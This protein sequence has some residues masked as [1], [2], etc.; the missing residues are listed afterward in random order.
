MSTH[1]A[2][3]HSTVTPIDMAGFTSCSDD[4]ES[5]IGDVATPTKLSAASHAD[6]DDT[7]GSPLK[8]KR[9]N[10]PSDDMVGCQA[11]ARLAH[12]SDLSATA[13]TTS[14]QAERTPPLKKTK[15]K[16]I[17]SDTKHGQLNE[18]KLMQSD[19]L[20]VTVDD[21]ED[22][23]FDEDVNDE[24]YEQIE[25]QLFTPLTPDADYSWDLDQLEACMKQAEQL[26]STSTLI[27]TSSA[28]I[29]S[30]RNES[31]SQTS[32]HSPPPGAN[33]DPGANHEGDESDL[34]D[35]CN[36]HQGKRRPSENDSVKSFL[37]SETKEWASLS[38]WDKDMQSLMNSLAAPSPSF[39]PRETL[40]DR[41]SQAFQETLPSILLGILPS[42][43]PSPRSSGPSNNAAVGED[44]N[45]G[46]KKR[47][48]SV[49]EN[50]EPLDVSHQATASHVAPSEHAQEGPPAK[51]QKLDE[52]P[53]RK[54][55]DSFPVKQKETDR[56]HANFPSFE[57]PTTPSDR[58]GKPV[59]PSGAIW[60]LQDM[61]N[62]S[63]GMA[64]EPISQDSGHL[65]QCGL[66]TRATK[67]ANHDS[68]SVPTPNMEAS[69]DA[70]AKYFTFLD[71][72]DLKRE[73]QHLLIS[74]SHT[75]NDISE[76]LE[77]P[78]ENASG[79]VKT[80][81][82]DLAELYK[83]TLQTSAGS[84]WKV[85]AAI[86]EKTKLTRVDHVLT[87]LFGRYLQ[88]KIFEA[89]HG[90][91]TRDSMLKDM[92][93][94]KDAFFETTSRYLGMVYPFL[95]VSRTTLTCKG[96]SFERFLEHACFQ[97][98]NDP[99]FLA[100][101][102]SKAEDL[103]SDFI[104]IIADHLEATVKKNHTRDDAAAVM[105][106]V[107]DRFDNLGKRIQRTIS[108]AL[109]LKAKLEMSIDEY[110]TTL[111]S[112]K[113]KKDLRVMIEHW[114]SENDGPAMREDDDGAPITFAMT[115]CLE[116]LTQK[117]EKLACPVV[118]ARAQVKYD[119]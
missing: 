22:V 49:L 64:P 54:D 43:L 30:S 10:D 111:Y 45:I 80:P 86:L 62:L 1:K 3:D 67:P 50:D 28:S 40:P 79:F 35:G 4:E 33:H 61:P 98:L 96:V 36:E 119:V 73:Y 82:P 26:S 2:S 69:A 18:R 117:G 39:A 109:E 11:D 52:T 107:I 15:T 74:I 103:A 9:G 20:C 81:E 95:S 55:D 19:S 12:L 31:S 91:I 88:E 37:E 87:A 24:T 47:D 27:A 118:I 78:D 76:A 113:A 8:R 56:G 41:R 16:N 116:Q 66:H 105:T 7:R 17:T 115:P 70:K 114:R 48:S 97:Q 71:P 21:Q 59:L 83:K 68:A 44:E 108:A 85:A 29:D 38:I 46:R 32:D 60:S 6:C 57:N 90:W 110:R 104:W 72:G 65:D 5:R 77:L 63:P 92:R 53:Y 14:V 84:R 25:K 34:E 101:I 112:R 100:S 93:R 23:S 94:P 51:K 106:R 99:D 42:I 89:D 13:D 58:I 75:I 102:K